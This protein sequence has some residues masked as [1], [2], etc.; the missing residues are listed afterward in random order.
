VYLSANLLDILFG[1]IEWD[2]ANG[3]QANREGQG[4][5][6]RTRAHKP[7]RKEVLEAWG[8]IGSQGA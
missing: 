8:I 7:E 5:T 4:R 6:C 3:T 1:E 2:T